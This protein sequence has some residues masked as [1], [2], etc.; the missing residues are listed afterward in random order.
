[1]Q[2][3][4]DGGGCTMQVNLLS[5]AHPIV[6]GSSIGS[7]SGS[8]VRRLALPHHALTSTIQCKVHT[9]LRP[10]N[11]LEDIYHGIVTNTSSSTHLDLLQN[12]DTEITITATLFGF[13]RPMHSLDVSPSTRSSTTSKQDTTFMSQTTNN[14]HH[15]HHHN[16]N[17]KHQNKFHSLRHPKDIIWDEVLDLPVRWKDILRDACIAFDIAGPS[18]EQVRIYCIVLDTHIFTIV[19]KNNSIML[20][21]KKHRNL[22]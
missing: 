5:S 10:T 2:T 8:H 17:N 14:Q 22:F 18:G 1:M 4:A 20:C 11:S 15:H 3:A 16:N 9:L 12:T 19:P 7:G 21:K 13:G 6:S